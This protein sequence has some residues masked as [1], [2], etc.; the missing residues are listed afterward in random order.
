MK[1]FCTFAAIVLLRGC[2]PC[3]AAETNVVIFI[4]PPVSNAAGLF[5]YSGP[6]S[7]TYTNRVPLALT[8]RVVYPVHGHTFLALSALGEDLL[9]ETA[10]SDEAEFEPQY[11]PIFFVTIPE[12]ALATNAVVVEPAPSF[13]PEIGWRVF[14]HL[15]RRLEDAPAVIEVFTRPGDALF[16]DARAALGVDVPKSYTR[17]Q[18]TPA[19]PLPAPAPSSK[20][21]APRYQ[22]SKG[23]GRG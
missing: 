9:F 5:L 13:V 14:I 19:P 1:W 17:L 12:M 16:V 11:S 23:G 6:A 8:N 3:P 20:L 21:R 10:L 7:R 22:P 2:V 15:R 18:T 4:S